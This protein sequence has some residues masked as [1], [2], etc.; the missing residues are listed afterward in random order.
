MRKPTKFTYPVKLMPLTIENRPREEFVQHLNEIP[1][2]VYEV[3]TLS[4]GRKIVINKP[5]GKRNYG[6]LPKK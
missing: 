3:E 4:D 5:G 1:Y 2:L 6:K